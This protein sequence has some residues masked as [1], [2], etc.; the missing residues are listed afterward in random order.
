M[1]SDTSA[2]SQKRFKAR[3]QNTPPATSRAAT[4]GASNAPNNQNGCANFTRASSDLCPRSWK[5]P[6]HQRSQ[7]G[8]AAD[9]EHAGQEQES[10][11][12]LEARHTRFE[13]GFFQSVEGLVHA[14]LQ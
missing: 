1:S 7:Q 13:L 11:E 12:L 14:G 4:T 9:E 10:V 8:F 6:Q 5:P 3:I 2:S